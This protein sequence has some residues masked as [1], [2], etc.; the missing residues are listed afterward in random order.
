MLIE[1]LEYV[2]KWNDDERMIERGDIRRIYTWSNVY[3]SFASGVK[4]ADIPKSDSY[5]TRGTKIA[6]VAQDLQ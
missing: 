1:E 3:F 2:I 6:T 5:R 4:S